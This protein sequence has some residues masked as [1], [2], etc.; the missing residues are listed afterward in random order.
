MP[1]RPPYC[2]PANSTPE[3]VTVLYMLCLLSVQPQLSKTNRGGSRILQGRVSNPSERG[4]GGGKAPD[5]RADG[6][7]GAFPTKFENLDTLRCIFPAFQGQGR[8]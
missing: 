2:V 8:S 4:T 5:V 3:N 1:Q 6:G 7:P